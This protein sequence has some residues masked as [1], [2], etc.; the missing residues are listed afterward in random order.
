[1][2]S[3]SAVCRQHSWLIMYCVVSSRPLWCPCP[4]CCFTA[5]GYSTGFG[6]RYR[7]YSGICISFPQ[8]TVGQPGAVYL[9]GY[10]SASQRA[11]GKGTGTEVGVKGTGCHCVL[12]Q[13]CEICK[14]LRHSRRRLQ[15]SHGCLRSLDPCTHA[16]MCVSIHTDVPHMRT[17]T[18]QRQF[19]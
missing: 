13:G 6:Q 12:Q 2:K 3:T 15:K 11:E 5:T 1:M 9:S 18:R 17:H 16:R 4:S 14:C 7:R 8:S 19:K 10:R